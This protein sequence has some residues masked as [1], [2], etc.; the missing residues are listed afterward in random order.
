MHPYK[1]ADRVR[2]YSQPVA[3][4]LAL[5]RDAVVVDAH[6]DIL[7][8]VA[9]HREAGLGS[10]FRA[11]WTRELRAGGVDVQVLPVTPW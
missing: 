5:H 10:A 4:A 8:L 7:L 1:F 2:A 3:D 11:R 9:R 6:H